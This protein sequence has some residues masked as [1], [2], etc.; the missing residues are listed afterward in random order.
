MQQGGKFV[1]EEE[2]KRKKKKNTKSFLGVF[3]WL[4]MCVS[5][6]A[7]ECVADPPPLSL[8]RKEIKNKVERRNH[9]RNDGGNINN[10][11]Q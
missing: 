5:V 3:F 6:R 9:V 1:H 2:K 11:K 8:V 7:F 4:Y 10:N